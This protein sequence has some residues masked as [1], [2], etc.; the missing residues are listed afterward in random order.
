M[1]EQAFLE[2]GCRR[3]SFQGALSKPKALDLFSGT[4]SV[5]T[6]LKEFGYQVVSLD[7]SAQYGADLTVDILDW[8]YW[9]IP[10]RTYEIIVASP[11]CT[12]FSVAK[13]R[14]ERKLDSA[15]KIVEK[16]LE[17]IQY[18]NPR[19]WWLENPRY[20]KLVRMECM[21]EFFYWDVDY[22]RFGRDF[23]KPTRFYDLRS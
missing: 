9:R 18:F 8:E 22:C 15:L 12:E 11:P 6:V 14:G 13:T 1:Q 10:P 21:Q 2:R 3:V 5:S 17:I 7:F 19:F 4:G 23:Q 20:G 16:T